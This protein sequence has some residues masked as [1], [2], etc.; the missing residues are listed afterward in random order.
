MRKL[1]ETHEETIQG[2]WNSSHG[3]QKSIFGS[4]ITVLGTDDI[5]TSF[6][7]RARAFEPACI[8]GISRSG[9][10]EDTSYDKIVKVDKLDGVFVLCLS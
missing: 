2:K 8:I 10:C 9:I 3:I 5:G 1:T 6:S 4:R 7:R